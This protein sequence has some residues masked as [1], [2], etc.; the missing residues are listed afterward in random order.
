MRSLVQPPTQSRVS[1][2]LRSDYL[3]FIRSHPKTSKEA[4]CTASLGQLFHWLTV[5]MVT[6]NGP[7]T[8]WVMCRIWYMND[9]S[10]KTNSFLILFTWLK[11]ATLK[12]PQV[13]LKYISIFK[14]FK[15]KQSNKQTTST[16][17]QEESTQLMVKS[18]LDS[19]YFQN[20]IWWSSTVLPE[21]H[22]ISTGQKKHQAGFRKSTRIVQAVHPM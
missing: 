16:K 14:A 9:I 6:N 20:L 22:G 17:T 5:V 3:V 21:K 7:F 12:T 11:N 1:F 8:E 4:D 13:S 18:C 10:W 19:D 2:E 15:N